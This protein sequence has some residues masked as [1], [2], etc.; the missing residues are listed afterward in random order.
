MV[1]VAYVYAAKRD[2]RTRVEVARAKAEV[3]AASA[4]RPDLAAV[5]RVERIHTAR[6]VAEVHV[7]MRHRWT[8]FDRP[9]GVVGPDGAAI[10]GPQA[11]HGAGLV[12][13]VHIAVPNYGRGLASRRHR[14]RPHDAAGLH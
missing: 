8:S 3:G 4:D 12:P 9:R 1:G 13:E 6:V 7:P 5:V 2:R 10:L 11:V 14:V